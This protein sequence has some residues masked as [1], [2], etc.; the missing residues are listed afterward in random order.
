MIAPGFA[1]IFYNNS[2]KNGLLPVPLPEETVNML[3]D[4]VEEDPEIQITVDLESQTV[5]LPDGQTHKFAIDPFRKICLL[6]GL[7]DLGYILSKVDAI[8]A[9]E[10]EAAY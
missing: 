5:A 3:L 2:L 8:E 1:D 10:A 9:H 4:L 6:E 7:D